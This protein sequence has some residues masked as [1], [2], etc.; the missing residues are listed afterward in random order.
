MMVRLNY[1]PNLRVTTLLSC[2]GPRHNLPF[3]VHPFVKIINAFLF[4]S[5]FLI[6]IHVRESIKRARTSLHMLLQFSSI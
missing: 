3:E 4:L 2:Y 5:S 1:P 6:K